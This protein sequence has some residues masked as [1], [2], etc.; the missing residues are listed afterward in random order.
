LKHAIFII[1]GL[2]KNVIPTL[3][4]DAFKK[5]GITWE[6]WGSKY[7]SRDSSSIASPPPKFGDIEVKAVT[8]DII[9]IKLTEL[10]NTFFIFD[11]SLERKNRFF[12]Q[13]L[14]EQNI[15]YIVIINRTSFIHRELFYI[16]KNG[17]KNSTLKLLSNI[18]YSPINRFIN[19]HYSIMHK[20][21]IAILGTKND[22]IAYN[23]PIPKNGITYF[24]NENYEKI[25]HLTQNITK[26]NTLVFV[27]Q[28]LPWHPDTLVFDKWKMNPETYYTKIAKFLIEIGTQ[29]DLKPII[30]AHPKTTENIIEPYVQGIPLIYGRTPDL[31]ANAGLVVQHS[32]LT[33]EQAIIMEKPILLVMCD[34][35][36]N[37]PIEQAVKLFASNLDGKILNIETFSS[38]KSSSQQISD[39]II[40]HKNQYRNY[41]RKNLKEP[42]SEKISYWEFIA[43]TIKTI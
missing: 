41:I 22:L 8:R 14:K 4:Q 19:N 27:D 30:A 32:S 23:Y 36:L 37:S 25:I 31:I 21:Q 39:Y 28:Y 42:N 1:K 18:L 9:D 5:A 11:Y 40:N 3:H 2:E 10:K 38:Q 7:L 6:F 34:E 26:G 29:L 16:K 33:I 13:K 20:P 12:L 24:H 17:I 15:P 43:Q 35:I